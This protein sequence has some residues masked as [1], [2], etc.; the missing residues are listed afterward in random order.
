MRKKYRI[1]KDS[2]SIGVSSYRIQSLTKSVFKKR[3]ENIHPSLTFQNL[4]DC[5]NFIF[6]INGELRESEEFY[7]SCN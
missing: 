1:V 3:W 6:E 7:F 5:L 4:V 2:R